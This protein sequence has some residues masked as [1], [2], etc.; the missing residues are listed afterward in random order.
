MSNTD[1][2]KE[3]SDEEYPGLHQKYKVFDAETDEP[4]RDFCFVLKPP[5][6]PEA[7]IACWAYAEIV[8]NPTLTEDLLVILH[9]LLLNNPRLAEE[10]A[11]RS[12]KIDSI[13]QTTFLSVF[14]KHFE[15]DVDPLSLDKMTMV[16]IL[17]LV[18]KRWKVEETLDIAQWEPEERKA[19][20]DWV[21]AR[22]LCKAR[23][24]K[25]QRQA[26]DILRDRLAS[27]NPPKLED[28]DAP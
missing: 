17:S 16:D 12:N 1:E 18:F 15:K 27:E 28:V 7:F 4:I 24:S 9:L 25:E 13:N 20:A 19:V 6:D 11:D 26:P 23:D 8:D 5:S 21:G 10:V 2:L 14:D 22:H 3:D